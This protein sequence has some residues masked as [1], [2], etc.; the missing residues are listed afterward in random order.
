MKKGLCR[1]GKQQRVQKSSR[2]TSK[3]TNEPFR[4]SLTAL[5]LSPKEQAEVEALKGL[6][7]AL[8]MEIELVVTR[9]KS[10][11]SLTKSKLRYRLQE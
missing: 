11:H 6:L 3:E 9:A 4:L 10:K 8:N 5:Q 2:R 7:E 1:M